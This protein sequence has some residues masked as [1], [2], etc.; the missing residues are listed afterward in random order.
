MSIETCIAHAIHKD[1]DIIEA[2]PEVQDL[3]VEQLESYVEHYILKVQESLC[4]VIE[5]KGDSYIRSKD[6]AGLC[7]ACL[8]SGVGLPPRMLLR[9]C[10]TIVQLTTLDARFILDTPEGKTLYYVRMAL[11]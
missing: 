6:A 5:A 2:I 7:A 11:V 3:P 10:Q 4:N 1:L 9:M 8:E